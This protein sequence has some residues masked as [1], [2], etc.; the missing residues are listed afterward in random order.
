MLIEENKWRAV[1]YGLEGQ[2]IDFGKRE[3]LSTKL[4]VE[5]LLDFVTEAADIFQTQD[6]LDRVR[7]ICQEGTSADRQLRIFKQTQSFKAV[8]DDLVDQTMLGA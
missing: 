5:E 3:Q 4:L 1:R 2:L 6:D 8:V 7:T